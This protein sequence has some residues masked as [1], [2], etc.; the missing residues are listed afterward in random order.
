MLYNK[1]SIKIIPTAPIITCLLIG[2]CVFQRTKLIRTKVIIINLYIKRYKDGIKIIVWK[3]LILFTIL[4]IANTFVIMVIA[5]ISMEETSGKNR[6]LYSCAL[7]VVIIGI[8]IQLGAVILLN[9][10]NNISKEN[11]AL[12]KNI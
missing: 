7:I 4:T 2:L 5:M 8:F 6:L 1:T 3:N 12:A 9:V 10:S 11:E